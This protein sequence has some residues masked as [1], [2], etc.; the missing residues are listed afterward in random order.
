M[1]VSKIWNRNNWLLLNFF[2]CLIFIV[3]TSNMACFPETKG[4]EEE[5]SEFKIGSV[6]IVI[7]NSLA[8]K[9]EHRP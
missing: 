5:K 6:N 2:I 9:K 3:E 8:R 7:T 4:K 1:H